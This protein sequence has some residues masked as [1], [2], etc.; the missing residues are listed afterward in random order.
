M[1]PGTP[2]ISDTPRAPV[3]ATGV[4]ILNMKQRALAPDCWPGRAGPELEIWLA[5]ENDAEREGGVAVG[6]A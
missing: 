5:A 1:V 2:P 3:N 6:G 4:T